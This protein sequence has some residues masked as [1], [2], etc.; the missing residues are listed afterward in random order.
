MATPLLILPLLLT[1][2]MYKAFQEE[3]KI[4]GKI[5]AYSKF[6][7]IAGFF[8]YI[9]AAII[10]ALDNARFTDYYS[11]KRMGILLIF[12]VIDVILSLVFLLDKGEETK[13]DEGEEKHADNPSSQR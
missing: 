12:L 7:S 9:K 11:L 8:P 10:P 3:K 5:Y 4:Y 1:L 13:Q 6:L 2:F